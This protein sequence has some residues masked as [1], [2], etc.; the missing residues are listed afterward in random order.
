MEAAGFLIGRSV[1]GV[2]IHA[3]G[4][5][6]SHGSGEEKESSPSVP[7]FSSIAWV[8]HPPDNSRTPTLPPDQQRE[9]SSGTQP[10]ARCIISPATYEF[11]IQRPY[12]SQMPL[13]LRTP[14]PVLEILLRRNAGDPAEKGR[15]RWFV[16]IKESATDS[17][18]RNVGRED[19]CPL[20]KL[21]MRDAGRLVK[22]SFCSETR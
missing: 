4:R 17:E 3:S 16:N 5:Y 7:A 18:R 20:Y 13:C 11:A 1:L 8:C 21:T 14:D 22:L 12:Q 10:T 6:Q 9:R 2:V 19:S 15:H